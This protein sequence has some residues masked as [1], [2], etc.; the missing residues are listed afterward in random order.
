VFLLSGE[1]IDLDPHGLEFHP[2]DLPINL[3]GNLVNP[4]L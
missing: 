1:L 2:S 3:V 4:L